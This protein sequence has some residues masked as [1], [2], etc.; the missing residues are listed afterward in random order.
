M[1]QQIYSLKEKLTCY[2]KF[3]LS[4]GHWTNESGSEPHLLA[5]SPPLLL[6]GSSA[7][8]LLF[9]SPLHLLQTSL[10]LLLSPPLLSLLLPPHLSLASLLLQDSRPAY[11]HYCAHGD[12]CGYA[13]YWSREHCYSSFNSIWEWQATDFDYKTTLLSSMAYSGQ[14]VKDYHIVTHEFMIMWPALLTPVAS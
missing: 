5:V 12:R 1:Y 13:H 8:L 14:I 7:L 6:L 11:S 3:I 9:T 4:N 2:L 10:L